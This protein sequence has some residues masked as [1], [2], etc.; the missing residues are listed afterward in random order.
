MVWFLWSSVTV[1]Q[2]R[3]KYSVFLR[4]EFPRKRVFIWL[5]LG[6]ISMNFHLEVS[7]RIND[8]KWEI[9]IGPIDFIYQGYKLVSFNWLSTSEIEFSSVSAIFFISSISSIS[10]IS[11]ID[12]RD[13]RFVTTVWP[14]VPN[15]S[16]CSVFPATSAVPEPLN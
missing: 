16:E 1:C 10:S 6:N 9:F 14:D 5:V 3:S 8:A 15:V 13:S 7:S 12:G 11:L 4:K 2:N